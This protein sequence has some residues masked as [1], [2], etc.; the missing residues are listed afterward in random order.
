MAGARDGL[1]PGRR[2][3]TAGLA[4]LPFAACQK[5]GAAAKAD[6]DAQS[7]GTMSPDPGRLVELTRL[8]PTIRLDIRYAT[9]DNF[10][11]QRLYDQAR[12]FLIAAAADALLRAHSRARRDGYGFIVYDAYR[13]LRVTQAMWN[14]TPRAKRN[15]VANPRKGS[16]H[17]RGC[18]IDLTLCDL[19]SGAAVEMPTPFD[20]FS[21]RAHRDYKG[22]TTV[23]AANR[24]RLQ[25]Y[26]EA[27]HFRGMSNEWW[28]FD[29]GGWE[30]FPIQDVPFDQIA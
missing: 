14:A 4:L 5:P 19:A 9:A 30:N 24:D 7:S 18:A 3:V 8:D 22:A 12:A 15:Y 21:I 17:N 11:G 6:S 29:Y 10:T 13:P 27:E 2:L 26:M 23:A 20:E 25:S 1:K 28:H 16:K